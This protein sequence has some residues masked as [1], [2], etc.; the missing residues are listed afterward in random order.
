[1]SAGHEHPAEHAHA[2]GAAAAGG[3]DLVERLDGLHANAVEQRHAVHARHGAERRAAFH[4][5]ALAQHIIEWC[6]R[7]AGFLD[8]RAAV[9][10]NA[11]VPGDQT[12]NCL[13]TES[14]RRLRITRLSLRTNLCVTTTR[15]IEDM[16]S[17]ATGGC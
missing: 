7:P 11:R 16:R 6:T 2:D 3:N 15:H 9:S 5:R 4:A 12:R 13:T 8:A 17:S 1:M 10:T 14:K